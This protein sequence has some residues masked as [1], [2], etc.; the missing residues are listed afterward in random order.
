[1]EGGV[2]KALQEE[3]KVVCQIPSC[4]IPSLT[5]LMHYKPTVVAAVYTVRTPP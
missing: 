5:L 3:D 1:M 4:F 2:Q